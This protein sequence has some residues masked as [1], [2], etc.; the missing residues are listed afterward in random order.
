M[1]PLII[2]LMS[3]HR[4]NKHRWNIKDLERNYLSKICM[5]IFYSFSDLLNVCWPGQLYMYIFTTLFFFKIES[6]IVHLMK[7]HPLFTS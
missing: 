4:G 7:L 1:T 3:N 5:Y 2:C 6:C